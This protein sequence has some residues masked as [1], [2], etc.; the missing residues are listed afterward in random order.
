MTVYKNKKADNMV[1]SPN[2]H[3]PLGQ[4]IKLSNGEYAL[5]VKKD[6]NYEE[7]PLGRLMPMIVQTAD[8]YAKSSSPK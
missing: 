1:Y 8:A 4:A 6:K 2:Q 3:I 7:I 5:R